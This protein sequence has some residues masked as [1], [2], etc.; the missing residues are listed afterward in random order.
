MFGGE[1][2]SSYQYQKILHAL[3]TNRKANISSDWEKT[4][5]KHTF[6]CFEIGQLSITPCVAVEVPW[7]Q[8]S[9]LPFTDGYAVAFEQR[10]TYSPFESDICN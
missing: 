3:H 2:Q 6:C 4:G 1:V 8:S 9:F 5:P 7:A 10:L